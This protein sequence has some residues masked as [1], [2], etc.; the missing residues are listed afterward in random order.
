MKLNSFVLQAG[1]KE[2]HFG[3]QD[4][5]LSTG[6]YLFSGNARPLPELSLF[7]RDYLTIPFTRQFLEL[8]AGIS[9]GWLGRK[10]Q[11]VKDAYLHHKF[12]FLRLGE[13][14]WKVSVNTG[15]HHAAMWGGISPDTGVL[16][17]NFKAFKSVLFG[18]IG[19]DQGPSGEQINVLGNHLATYSL[20]IDIKMKEYKLGFSWQTL[21]EDKNGR[22]GVDWK[23]REDG[24]WGVVLSK[25]DTTT[26][27]RKVLIEFVNTTNQSGDPL[28]SGDDDYFNNYLYKTGWTY[29]RMTIGTPLIT[30]P[31]YS[32]RTPLMYDYLENNSIKAVTTGFSGKIKDKYLIA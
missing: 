10:D 15:L 4:N 31:V 25:K 29:H 9:H 17:H 14:K 22:V 3:I 5:E 12:A 23:N 1:V 13:K 11:Y 32:K 19:G 28:K 7:T 26:F 27:F 30:S 18:K 6:N 2:E 20:G 24:I 16:P 8:K 21:L